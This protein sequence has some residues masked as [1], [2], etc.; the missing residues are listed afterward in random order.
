[1]SFWRGILVGA[2]AAIGGAGAL[3]W[4]ARVPLARKVAGQAI[5]KL[6]GTGNYTHNLAEVWINSI[7]RQPRVLFETMLR[8]EHGRRIARPLYTTKRFLHFD[9]LMFIPAQLSRL[10]TGENERIRLETVIG[11]RAPR[12]LVLDIPFYISGMAYGLSL[13]GEAK[14]ALARAAAAAGTATNSGEGGFFEPEREAARYYMLQY[15]RGGWPKD[16]ERLR[17]ADAI[18]IQVG[19]GAQA[20]SPQSTP[21]WKITPE[22]QEA[23][24]LPDGVDAL[25]HSRFPA[26]GPF[27]AVESPAGWPALVRAM[28]E[29]VEVPVGF[30]IAAGHHLE[31]DIRIAVEAGADFVTVDGA[32]GASHAAEPILLDDFGIP[33]LIA[34][35]RARRELERLGAE[36][37]LSLIVSGGIVTPSEMLKALALGATAVA[38]GST[39]LLAMVHAQWKKIA[40]FEPPTQLVLHDSKHQRLFDVDEG[41]RD[42][43]RWIWACVDEIVTGVR[44]V[45]KVDVHSVGR[46]DLVA[47]TEE[48]ARVTGLPLAWDAPRRG[49]GPGWEAPE[50]RQAPAPWEAPALRGAPA[51]RQGDD[52]LPDE[53]HDATLDEAI[54]MPFRFRDTGG[55]RLHAPHVNEID[56]IDPVH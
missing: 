17:R 22:M 2:A 53:T 45:G 33:T 8:A 42:C 6:T 56:R 25:I 11:P 3:F 30:K 26:S 54:I 40:P 47:L 39:P 41:A 28:K 18:E 15:T 44:C 49:Q 12:P 13:T 5:E 48:A 4:A 37:D 21:Y 27:P 29:I 55:A 24:E 46:E 19:Q 36:E 34:L 23:L 51:V 35:V 10:P 20:G 16:P 9:D 7:G 50:Q 14:V 52:H 1:M 31:D 32:Q 43:E 38:C